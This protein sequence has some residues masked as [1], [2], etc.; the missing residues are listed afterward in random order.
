MENSGE[1]CSLFHCELFEEFIDITKNFLVLLRTFKG[2]ILLLQEKKKEENYFI[3]LEI[4][5]PRSTWLLNKELI[6]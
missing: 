2:R 6:F 1:I 4:C 5:M 3:S